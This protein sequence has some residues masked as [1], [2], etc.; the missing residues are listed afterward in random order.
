MNKTEFV[1]DNETYNFLGFC[2]HLTDHLISARRPDF[3]FIMKKKK[4]LSSSDFAV[5][6]E[7]RMKINAKTK[8][9]CNMKVTVIPIVVGA[10]ITVPNDLE[11]KLVELEIRG[12]HDHTEHSIVGVG[13]NTEKSPGVLRRLAVA[14]NLV[15]E[16]LPTLV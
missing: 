7:H 1:L 2:D 12:R 13:K 10:L 11:K 16:H 6:P 3:V 14:K 4:Y 9:L 15:K 8:K 5:P